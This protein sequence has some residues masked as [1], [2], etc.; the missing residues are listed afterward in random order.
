M[1][2]DRNSDTFSF[3]ERTDCERARAN[4]IISRN[5]Q[6]SAEVMPPGDI[7]VDSEVLRRADN[8]DTTDWIDFR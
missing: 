2:S 5:G 4:L 1:E 8:L 6:V 3:E 7:D